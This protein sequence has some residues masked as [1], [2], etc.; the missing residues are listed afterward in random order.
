MSQKTSLGDRMK[1]YE[2]AGRLQL[3]GRMPLVIRLDGKAF[4]T[5]TKKLKKPY[6]TTLM[7]VMDKVAA[8]LCAEVQNTVMAYVQSDEISLLLIDF[9]T[10]YTTPWFGGSM[11]KMVSV[12]AGLASAKLTALSAEVFGET[13]EGVF[14][15][16]AFVLPAQE[17][18]N[19][20]V[21]RQQDWQRNSLSMLAQSLYSHK[22]LQ[23]KGR[24]QQHE[25]CFQK[26]HNW[27][28]L[29]SHIKDGRVIVKRTTTARDHT[30]GTLKWAALPETPIFRGD[31]GFI[32]EELNR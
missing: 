9:K 29:S 23:G 30:G 11:Q 26:G 25:M 15:A 14:D 19:Y 5:Y 10:L 22:E 16:R 13:R 1:G 24:E 2:S 32:E 8:H 7:S 20:F 27:A 21:W 12:A 17:V 3:P 28:N 4:H 6:D 31:G 18:G